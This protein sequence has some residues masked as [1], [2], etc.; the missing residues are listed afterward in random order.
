MKGIVPLFQ[1]GTDQFIP[2]SPSWAVREIGSID[3]I[4]PP[5]LSWLSPSVL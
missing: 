2:A 3:I 5:I 4:L 1:K